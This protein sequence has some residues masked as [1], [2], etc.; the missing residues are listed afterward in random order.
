MVILQTRELK[1]YCSKEIMT[2]VDELVAAKEGIELR[3]GFWIEFVGVSKNR[4]TPTSS[5]S[6]GFSIINHP[7]WGFSPYFLETS[8]CPHFFFKVLQIRKKI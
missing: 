6:V 5:I 2:K 4:G 8:L 1:P 7:F 3:Q